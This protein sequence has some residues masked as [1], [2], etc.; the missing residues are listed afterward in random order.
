MTFQAT[1]N[2]TCSLTI[3]I[4]TLD[5]VHQSVIILSR[6]ML[7]RKAAGDGKAQKVKTSSSLSV[8]SGARPTAAQEKQSKLSAAEEYVFLCEFGADIVGS[9]SA[10]VLALEAA[11]VLSNSAI[12]W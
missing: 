7:E 12:L 5:R 10:F 9:I 2:T 8:V 1:S 6:K 4:Q 3:Y 11:G